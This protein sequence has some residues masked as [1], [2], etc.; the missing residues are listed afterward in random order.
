MKKR[1]KGL[2]KLGT[3]LLLSTTIV[4]VL[5]VLSPILTAEDVGSDY[6]V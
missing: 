1:Q 2:G 5:G 4:A 3:G 6:P